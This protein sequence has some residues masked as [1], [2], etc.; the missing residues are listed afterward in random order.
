MFKKFI[1]TFSVVTLGF[2]VFN[3]M[4]ESDAERAERYAVQWDA[5]DSVTSVTHMSQDN[6]CGDQT[7]PYAVIGT[8]DGDRLVSVLCLA[9]TEQFSYFLAAAQTG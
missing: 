7:E 5:V 8:R 6:L 2:V 3:S 1:L 4:V 9:D